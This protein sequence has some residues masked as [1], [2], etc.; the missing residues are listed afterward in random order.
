MFLN[1][2]KVL[3][4]WER[5]ESRMWEKKVVTNY[6]AMV[7]RSVACKVSKLRGYF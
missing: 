2:E 5:E 4:L 3:E 6:E 7:F 1:G